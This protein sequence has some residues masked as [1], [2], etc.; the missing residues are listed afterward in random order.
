MLTEIELQALVQRLER[1]EASAQLRAGWLQGSDERAKWAERE[2][3]RMS[4]RLQDLH[5]RWEGQKV[6]IDR[7][8]GTCDDLLKRF[9]AWKAVGN[10]MGADVN[11]IDED[12]SSCLTLISTHTG[13]FDTVYER[14]DDVEARLERHT[15]MLAH[16]T[17]MAG[18]LKEFMVEV[19]RILD[20]RPASELPGDEVPPASVQT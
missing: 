16:L 15:Q 8:L 2:L 17:E 19:K 20:I 10:E 14:V 11:R 18:T 3:E 13:M 5:E 1:L 9:E 6:R 4:E 12:M 7:I